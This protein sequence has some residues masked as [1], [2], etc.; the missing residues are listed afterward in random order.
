MQRRPQKPTIAA[1]SNPVGAP[2]GGISA[3]TQGRAQT[4]KESLSKTNFQSRMQ[5]SA[6]F[7]ISENLGTHITNNNQKISSRS[8]RAKPHFLPP[9]TSEFAQKLP[10]AATAVFKIEKNFAGRNGGCRAGKFGE[11][12]EVWRGKGTLRKGPLPPPRSF[13]Y[14]FFRTYLRTSATARSE[15]GMRTAKM[16]IQ[17]TKTVTETFRSEEGSTRVSPM[18]KR[19]SSSAS[20]ERTAAV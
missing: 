14:P 2:A 8:H 19:I 18:G 13:P 7:V 9:R 17:M 6:Y 5:Q 12:R 10:C 15:S 11:M 16:T 1:E 3:L 4:A 20:H